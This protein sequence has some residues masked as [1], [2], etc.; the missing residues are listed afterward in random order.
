MVDNM[1]C[2]FVLEDNGNEDCISLINDEIGSNSNFLSFNTVEDLQNYI[3]K[4]TTQGSWIK[5]YAGN[6]LC[7]FV[8][9]YANNFKTLESY[10]TL[11]LIARKYR[12]KGIATELLNDLFERLTKRGFINCSLEVDIN[13]KNAIE[14]Y[15]SLGFEIKSRNANKLLLQK[16]L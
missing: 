9:Y 8:C 6:N 2:K 4:I 7:G 11:V 5:G 15:N 13:N 12:K 10:I 14:L 1:E 3:H 16:I